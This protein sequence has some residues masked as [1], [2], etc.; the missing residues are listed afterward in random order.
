M[1]GA[2]ILGQLRDEVPGAPT[3]PTCGRSVDVCTDCF[4]VA[5]HWPGDH[6]NFAL[7]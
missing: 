5:R 3:C 1:T 4:V 6:A 2:P 7:R